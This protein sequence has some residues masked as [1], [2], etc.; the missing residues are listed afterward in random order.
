MQRGALLQILTSE[1]NLPGFENPV[2]ADLA[3]FQLSDTKEHEGNLNCRAELLQYSRGQWV[4]RY[5][6]VHA[7]SS[8]AM[9]TRLPS[10]SRAACIFS[11]LVSWFGSSMS[12]T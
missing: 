11:G 3:Q 8:Y 9:T 12:R 5:I 7:A 6:K 2:E 4:F 10:A 1:L